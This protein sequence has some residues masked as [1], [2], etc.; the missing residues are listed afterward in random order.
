MSDYD[1]PLQQAVYGAL[2]GA[3]ISGVTAISDHPLIDPPATAYPYLHIA[4]ADKIADD[5]SCADGKEIY[6]SIHSWSRHRGKKEITLIMSA[7]HTALHAQ[8]LTVAGLSSCLAFVT[9]ER[10]LDDP[11]G[12]TRHGVTTLKLL[13]RED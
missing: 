4:D 7:I 13:C 9:F 8:S 1:W 6:F 11:D 5:V 12:L 3:S 10:L 2:D